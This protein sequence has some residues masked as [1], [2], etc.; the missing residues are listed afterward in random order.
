MD[1]GPQMGA[2]SWKP[3]EDGAAGRLEIQ[4]HVQ[5]GSWRVVVRGEIDL[6]TVAVLEDELAG[7]ESRPIVLDLSGV[8][9]IDST[10]LTLLVRTARRVTIGPVSAAVDR[11][12]QTCGLETE[13][14]FAD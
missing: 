9:F 8:S 4:T 3:G 7:L 12:I 13:L 5:D 11:L 1:W 14:R 6:A 10:G 2:K